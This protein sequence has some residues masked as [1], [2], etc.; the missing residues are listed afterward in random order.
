MSNRASQ[1]ICYK[2]CFDQI[3]SD[4]IT[5][6]NL[7][8]VLPTLANDGLALL[9]FVLQ[10]LSLPDELLASAI[11]NL[12]KQLDTT[13]LARVING[14]SH[15]ICT[16]HQ[17]SAILGVTEPASRE[18]FRQFVDGVGDALDSQAAQEALVAVAEDLFV[19]CA[20][21]STRLTTEPE[22]LQ[23]MV[24]T[25][26]QLVN[27]FLQADLLLMR[28]L[29]QIPDATWQQITNQVRLDGSLLAQWINLNLRTTDR[30][31]CELAD[32]TWWSDAKATI[33]WRRLS[34]LLVRSVSPIIPDLIESVLS[35][36]TNQPERL[37]GWTNQQLQRLNQ[38]AQTQPDSLRNLVTR[39]WS[40]IDKTELNKAWLNV[41]KM[42]ARLPLAP[43]VP[44]VSKLQ[45]FSPLSLRTKLRKSR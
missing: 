41:G 14:F 3:L 27:A 35:T 6:A 37:A 42:C 39:F 8:S 17:G 15:T 32:S 28:E 12:L 45:S 5:L 18:V 43:F 26:S 19:V 11:F 9:A 33:D 10:N 13:T 2:D 20:V 4:P 22:S 30:L 31:Q 25:T 21:I 34:D 23:R 40:A 1:E 16:L 44:L 38:I 29:E 24:N 7:V 36:G